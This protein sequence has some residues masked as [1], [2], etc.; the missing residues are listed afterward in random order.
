MPSSSVLSCITAY[1]LSSLLSPLFSPLSRKRSICSEV[2]GLVGFCFGL[3]YL[4]KCSVFV[5]EDKVTEMCLSWE[6]D[7]SG[8]LLFT[9]Q[10]QIGDSEESPFLTYFTL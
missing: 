10:S 3:V 8:V 1:L 4:H 5:R 2:F 6:A 9:A 7:R